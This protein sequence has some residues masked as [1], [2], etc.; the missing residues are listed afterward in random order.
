MVQAVQATRKGFPDHLPFAELLSR[1]ELVVP[2]SATNKKG[3]DGVRA[4][5]SSAGV[6]DKEFRIGKTKVF[7]GVGV[8]DQLEQRRMEYIASK[9]LSCPAGE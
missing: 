3:A 5:L 4:L 1:F 2:K 7:L 6:S 8:L 9:V